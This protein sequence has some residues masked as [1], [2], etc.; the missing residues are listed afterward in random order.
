MLN[1]IRAERRFSRIL[2]AF[3][4]SKIGDGVHEL[5]F[6][7]LSIQLAKNNPTALSWV[8]FFRFAPYLV[9]GPIGGGIADRHNCKTLMLLSDGVRCALV[10]VLVGLGHTEHLTL[11]ELTVL[12]FLMTSFRTVFQPAFQATIPRVVSDTNRV[13]G[14]ALVQLCTELGALIGPAVAGMLL[15]TISRINV[16]VIDAASYALGF[17]I[18]ASTK[19]PHDISDIKRSYWSYFED[20]LNTVREIANNKSLFAVILVSG[21]SVLAV[22]ASLRILIPMQARLSLPGDTFVGFVLASVSAGT[23]AGAFLASRFLAAVNASKLAW[24]W[25]LYGVVLMM[26]CLSG[27]PLVLMLATFVLGVVG[28]FVDIAITTCIQN[29]ANRDSIGKTFSF[30]STAAN[31]GEAMSPFVATAILSIF[32]LKAALGLSGLLV[33]VFVGMGFLVLQS[34]A[35]SATEGLR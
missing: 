3:F 11:T 20:L 30:F 23:V 6:F 31:A 8:Y 4:I 34:D 18:I 35:R 25:F 21:G 14:H 24:F 28:A 7:L 17:A 33:L 19:I 29:L 9:F 26:L 15:L 12:G 1:T 32:S 22:G 27:R 2:L 16:L 10:L 5:I 13:A